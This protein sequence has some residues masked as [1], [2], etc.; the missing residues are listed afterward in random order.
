MAFT[1]EEQKIKG[2]VVITP[3]IFGDEGGYFA[4]TF[5]TSDFVAYEILITFVQDHHF[6][7]K[8]KITHN[9][10]VFCLYYIQLN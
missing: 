8:N 6:T 3:Q 7:L 9:T 2:M 5:K 1:F 10:L 4:E